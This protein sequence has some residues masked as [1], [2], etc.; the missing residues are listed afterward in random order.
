VSANLPTYR[1]LFSRAS[2]AVSSSKDLYY[3]QSTL[4]VPSYAKMGTGQSNS[5]SVWD[6]AEEDGDTIPLDRIRRE[7]KITTQLES[8]EN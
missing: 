3:H 8:R 2:Q 7:V 6:N 1:P 4:K 5:D